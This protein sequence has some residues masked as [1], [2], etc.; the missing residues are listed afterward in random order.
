MRSYGQANTQPEE[1]EMQSGSEQ[2]ELEGW[3]RF[4][5]TWAT[6]ATHPLLPATVVHGQ[7]TFE[8]LEGRRFV[9]V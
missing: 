7:T 5:G 4:V 6:E 1:D 2:P 8:W 9:M 3:Q